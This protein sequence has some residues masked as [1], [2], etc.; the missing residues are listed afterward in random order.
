[1]SLKDSSCADWLILIITTV[2]KQAHKMQAYDG[3]SGM[4]VLIHIN[5]TIHN[6]KTKV[7]L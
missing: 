4:A 6:T 1:M 3:N 2:S 7:T 5:Y